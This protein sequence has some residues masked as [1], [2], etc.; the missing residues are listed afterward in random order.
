VFE[1]VA[2]DAVVI[3]LDCDDTWRLLCREY[4][5]RFDDDV[6]VEA[7]VEDFADVVE[8]ALVVGLVVLSLDVV[9]VE[10]VFNV[11]EVGFVVVNEVDRVDLI[12]VG[13]GAEVEE[14]CEERLVEED[15]TNDVVEGKV[16]FEVLDAAC[17]LILVDATLADVVLAGCVEAGE[18]EDVEVMGVKGL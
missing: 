11:V 14:I 17:V 12:E 5:Y 13:E 3:V 1:A 2:R 15:C 4:V 10:E 16:D 18:V 6:V 9:L 8:A 7:F